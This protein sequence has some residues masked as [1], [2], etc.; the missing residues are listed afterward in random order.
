M[1]RLNLSP[2]L[3]VVTYGA[4]VRHTYFRE[5]IFTSLLIR[6]REMRVSNW[7]NR[8]EYPFESNYL[9]VRGGRLHYIDE[10]RGKPMV[11][12]H[13]FP[14]WSFLFRHLIKGLSSDYRCI[15]LDHL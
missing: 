11:M 15:A 12:V 10:G 14:T 8:E 4:F 6:E 7:V 2:H 9:T 1:R 3:L 13:G 5:V